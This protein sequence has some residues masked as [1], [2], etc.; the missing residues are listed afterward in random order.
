MK[1]RCLLAFSFALLLV[2]NVL[3]DGPVQN[4]TQF[5]TGDVLRVRFNSG[6]CFHFYTYDLVFERGES[7]R[8][9]ITS[10]QQ[11]WSE[12]K[13]AYHDGESEKL[14]EFTLTPADLSGLDKLLAFYRGVAPGGCTTVDH[15]EISQWRSG[16]LIGRE[17]FTDGTC[18]R[19]SIPGMLTFPALARRLRQDN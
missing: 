16:A 10:V 17:K 7:T 8:V 4:F 3:A 9:S 14:G 2:T 15:V 18:A 12:R 11:Q 19:H 13:Q 1:P 6:G 5:P